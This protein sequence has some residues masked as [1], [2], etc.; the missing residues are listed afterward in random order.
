MG[1]CFDDDKPRKEVIA[2]TVPK[3]L[4]NKKDTNKKK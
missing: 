2:Q 1:N 3:D 4:K